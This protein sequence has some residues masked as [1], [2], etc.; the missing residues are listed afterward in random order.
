[1]LKQ[2]AL[3]ASADSASLREREIGLTEQANRMLEEAVEREK[4]SGNL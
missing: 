2:D 1:M 3:A 4:M